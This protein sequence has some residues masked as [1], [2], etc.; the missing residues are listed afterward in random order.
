MRRTF[1][2]ILTAREHVAL[3]LH[4]AAVAETR[5]PPLPV[6][7]RLD[8]REDRLARGVPRGPSA[9][10][11]S[12]V[13]RVAKRLSAT[14]LSQQSAW[15]LMLATMPC[16]A[17]SFRYSPHAY[18]VMQEPGAG[19]R[20]ASAMRSAAS[21]RSASS[22]IAH[23][24]AARR[25]RG[26]SRETARPRAS[27]RPAPPGP[28]L[29]VDARRPIGA[30]ALRMHRAQLEPER[31]VPL[32]ACTRW[33]ALRRVEARGRHREHATHESHRILAA[34]ASKAGVPH[35]DSFAKNAARFLKKSL[36]P[37]ARSSTCRPTSTVDPA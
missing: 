16:A 31:L 36:G 12:S 10:R 14:A 32:G 20:P 37:P 11:I 34:V 21:A 29:G 27:W 13:S 9:S 17:S 3:V 6:V 1:W 2:V 4:R 33:P 24:P 18:R 22:V 8:V 7:P 35:R 23:P 26:R 25:G 30:A 5:V 15:L 19:R 28:Q